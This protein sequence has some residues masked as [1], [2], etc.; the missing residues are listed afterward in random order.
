MLPPPNSIP[1]QNWPGITGVAYNVA[2][3]QALGLFD[4]ARQM[5]NT[6]LD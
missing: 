3:A 1:W 5:G 2:L 6:V 4:L